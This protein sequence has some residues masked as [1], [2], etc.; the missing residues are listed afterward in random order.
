MPCSCVS[1][2]ADDASERIY[3]SKEE[4]GE[5][6]ARETERRRFRAPP[7]VTGLSQPTPAVPLKTTHSD[8]TCLKYQ[9]TLRQQV[10]TFS[11]RCSNSW[12]SVDVPDYWDEKPKKQALNCPPIISTHAQQDGQIK[13]TTESV[14]RSGR[15]PGKT[16][17]CGSCSTMDK[18]S[19][20]ARCTPETRENVG[21]VQSSGEAECHISL[22]SA[23]S[24][25][26][27]TS[28]PEVDADAA[29][30]VAAAPTAGAVKKKKKTVTFSDNVELVA[31]AG[32]VADPVDYLS[33][34]ASIGRQATSTIPGMDPLLIRVNGADTPS[35][36]SRDCDVVISSNS[37]DETDGSTSSGQVRCSL[38]RQKWVALTDTYCSDCSFYLSKL[39]M[40][41]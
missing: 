13:K 7:E 41:N 5:I 40:S 34:A 10:K 20:T 28:R 11:E 3:L 22:I 17:A 21:N 33:Y 35:D 27:C 14:C 9:D 25:K 18:T 26:P 19:V 38:C 32:D 39:E 4:V 36:C 30:S 23:D 8:H 6:L 16:S 37:S 31:S 1:A 24:V 12:E 15:M 29:A 2:K